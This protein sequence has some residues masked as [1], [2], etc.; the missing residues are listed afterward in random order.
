MKIRSL[1]HVGITVSS[2]KNSVKW[3]YDMF[4]LTLIDEQ[5]LNEE[6]VNNLSSLYKL[7][8]TSVHLGFLRIPKGGVIEIFEFTP[9]DNTQV[10][11]WNKPSITHLTLD[12]KNLNIWYRTLKA[13]GVNFLCEPQCTCGNDWVF[14]QDPDGNLIELIDLKINYP[15]IRLLGGIASKIMKKKKFKKYYEV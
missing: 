15:I 5:F 1:S 3:Y 2:F 6:Q 4:G 10:H 9:G 11:H 7:E 8:N 13:Q 12:V 14:L